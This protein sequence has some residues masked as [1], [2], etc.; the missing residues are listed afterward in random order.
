MQKRLGKSLGDRLNLLVVENPTR[1]QLTKPNMATS[2]ATKS[3][4]DT[5]VIGG[6]LFIF[7][8]YPNVI[9][10]FFHHILVVSRGFV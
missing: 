8:N 4:F 3:I 7:L 9:L 1:S 2:N 6:N 5:I 10:D